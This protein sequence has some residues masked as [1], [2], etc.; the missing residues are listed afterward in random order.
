V[1]I[2]DL[3]V[4][5]HILHSAGHSS[6]TGLVVTAGLMLLVYFL[7]G[8]SLGEGTYVLTLKMFTHPIFRIYVGILLWS[9]SFHLLNGIRHLTI[10]AGLGMEMEV[11]RATGRGVLIGATILAVAG[12]LFLF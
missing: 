3:P 5:L 7:T 4:A 11:A 12:C 6:D 1:A 10:D 8:V 2:L 9:F